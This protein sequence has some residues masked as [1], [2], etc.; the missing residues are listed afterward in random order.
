MCTAFPVTEEALIQFT[1]PSTSDEFLTMMNRTK[2]LAGVQKTRVQHKIGDRVH[3][4]GETRNLKRG[5]FTIYEDVTGT[6]I[7]IAPFYSIGGCIKRINGEL[8][9]VQRPQYLVKFD[10]PVEIHACGLQAEGIIQNTTKM[11]KI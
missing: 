10:H 9:A 4:K 11:K 6:V 7:G 8:F 5:S 2:T 1:N 3:I